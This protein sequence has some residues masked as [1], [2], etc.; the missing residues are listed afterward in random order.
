[1]CT[2]I[3]AT[4]FL[5]YFFK[6]SKSIVKSSFLISTNLGLRPQYNAEAALALNVIVG[7]KTSL[8]FLKLLHN[9]AK[10]NA[11]VPEFTATAYFVL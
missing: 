6:S 9:N 11:A 10:C 5:L 8:S 2:Q 3:K 7:T 4:Q 1:M